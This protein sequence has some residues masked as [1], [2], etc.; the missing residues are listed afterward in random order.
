MERCRS[1]LAGR[2]PFLACVAL[3]ARHSRRGRPTPTLSS[4]RERKPRGWHPDAR[5][6]AAG[7]A[8]YCFKTCAQRPTGEGRKQQG[9][10]NRPKSAV[11]WARAFRRV[12]NIRVDFLHK[13]S[14]SVAKTKSVLVLE[15]VKVQQLCQNSRLARSISEC[16]CFESRGMLAYNCIWYGSR[17]VLG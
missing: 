17:L 14:T 11:R 1:T 4:Q 13:L 16:D 2:K 7:H 15:D 6:S 3:R 10:R 9:S 5:V 8:P 12:R